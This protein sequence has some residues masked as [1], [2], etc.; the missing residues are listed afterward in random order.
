MKLK[1][2][3]NGSIYYNIKKN[4]PESVISN[5]FSSSRVVTEYH[6]KQQPAVSTR[7]IRI[8]NSQEVERY[9]TKTRKGNFMK[10]LGRLFAP[11]TA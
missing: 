9:L 5:T 6:G 7:Y 4:R 3:K 1:E 11:R 10:F 8:A 2:I